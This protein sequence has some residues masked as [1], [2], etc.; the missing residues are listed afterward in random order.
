MDDVYIYQDPQSK[1]E[2]QL[3]IIWT[4]SNLT[5]AINYKTEWF[6]N[7]IERKKAKEYVTNY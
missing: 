3:K 4:K 2:N 7:M 6:C 1:Q 5:K